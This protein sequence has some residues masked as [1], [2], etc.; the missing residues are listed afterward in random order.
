VKAPGVI[1]RSGRKPDPW[2]PP[3]WA[4]AGPD[5]TFGNRFNDPDATY[6]VL[7]ASSQRFGCFVE[8]LARFRVDPKLLAQLSQIEGEDDY[9][10]L[11]EVPVEWVEK[12]IMGFATTDKEYADVCSSEWISRLRKWL[13]VHLEK[14]ALDEFDAS[15]LQQTAPRTLTQSV[16]RIVFNDGFAGIY[17]RSKYGHDIENWALFEPFQIEV[18]EPELIQPDDPDMQRALKLHSLKFKE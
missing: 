9:C 16:S 14:F 3:D 10:P 18:R 13:A 15:V 4:S 6:R 5:G 11:G 17:Y 8:T 2:C 12:R 7:Y 1:Y